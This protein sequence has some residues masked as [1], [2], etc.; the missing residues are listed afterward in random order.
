M[1]TPT[2]IL[3]L[4]SAFIIVA[5]MLKPANYVPKKIDYFFFFASIVLIV[6][7]AIYSDGLLVFALSIQSFSDYYYL[8]LFRRKVVS[9][10]TTLKK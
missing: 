2:L 3:V 1:P 4:L 8:N 9:E 6:I 10:T 7:F 5:N